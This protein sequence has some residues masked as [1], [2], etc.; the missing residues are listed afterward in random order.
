[1]QFGMTVTT[2][3]DDADFAAECEGL[4]FDWLWVPDSQL[5]WGDCYA[6]M[7][8]AATRTERITL[9]TGV[10]V[11]GTRT[12]PVTAHSIAS[13]NTL[14]PGRTVLGIGSGNSAYRLMDHKPLPIAKYA[15]E[16]RVISALLAGE[17]VEFTFRGK[18]APIRLNMAGPGFMDTEHRVPIY[19]S[20]FGP[21]SQELAGHYGDG[22]V[23]SLPPHERSIERVLKTVGA[24]AAAAGRPFDPA[25]F[26]AVTLTN[27]VLLEPGESPTSERVLAV[28][29]PYIISSLH[30][31]LDQVRQYDREPPR[32]LQD[33]WDRYTDLLARTPEHTRH[34]RIHEGHCT[35]VRDDERPFLTEELVR[36]TCIVGEPD[37]CIAKLV[38]LERAGL[39]QVMVLPAFGTHYD[40]A[41]DFA[42]HVIARYPR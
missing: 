12:A 24:G 34:L 42:R 13:V 26:P 2:R 41:R 30:Y 35:Y 31:L 8:L 3:L 7:A 40:Y 37:E 18:T 15:E 39:D 16:L 14:A 6:Y 11:A 22:G 20:G 21:R 25:T 4:G 10:A 29:G 17:E 5:I 38:D 36:Q 19:V 9:A 33:L 32:H 23:T 28:H 27:V 1:M